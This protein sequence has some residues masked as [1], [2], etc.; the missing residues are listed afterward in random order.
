MKVDKPSG[1]VCPKDFFRVS[2]EVKYL[3]PPMIE[4]FEAAFA[5]WKDGARRA[6]SIRARARAWLIFRLL[7]HS[8][9]R[10]GEVLLLDDSAAF[11]GPGPSVR[12]G[13]NGRTRVVPLPE[14][15]HAEI[16]QTLEGP[17]GC[18]M[19]GGFFRL[20]PGYFRR[21]CYARGAE[22][23]LTRDMSGPTV[24]RNTRAVEM[25]RSGVPITVVKEVLGQSSLDL[26]AAYQQFTQGDVVSI[27][28]KS[29]R[30]R[31]SAR[32]AFVGHV[33]DIRTD[34]VMAE[35][36]MET[37][38]GVHISAVITMDSLHT[39]QLEPGA[40]V[41]ATVKAPLVNVVSRDDAVLGSARNR[42]RAKVIRLVDSPVLTEV[43]G[44]LPDGTDVCALVSSESANSLK[45]VPG[46]EVEF[47]FKALSV[48][49][50]T[51]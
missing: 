9:A 45:L 39:L 48:V 49:L 31:T 38:S 5:A 32:N 27:V 26:T 13:T 18:G 11:D 28:Q 50:N 19:R 23:G 20:D 21:I 47:W 16:I 34:T 25:L 8:G 3:E 36:R 24:L 1:R 43:L 14:E 10:L 42:L 33:T 6:D 41:A 4:A 17:I 37:R 22:C 40:P 51:V 12:L 7:R 35:V 44:R 2:E 29:V 30:N 46:T 15:V